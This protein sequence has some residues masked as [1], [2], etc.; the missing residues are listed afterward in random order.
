MGHFE[1]ANVVLNRFK[2]DSEK[3]FVIPVGFH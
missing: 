3:I 2:N 1:N